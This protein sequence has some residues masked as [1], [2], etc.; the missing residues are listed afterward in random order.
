MSTLRAE[1]ADYLAMRRA[2]GFS[3]KRDEKLLAQF[4]DFLQ[5]QHTDLV[6][7][8]AALA[9]ASLPAGGPSWL[10]L[11]LSVVR[12]FA[13]HLHTLNPL[14][15]VPPPGLLPGRA[16]RMVP[17]L[18]CDADILAL[19]DAT[20]TLR[21]EL[22]RATYRTL[23]GLLAAT[24]MR[25]GEAL[26]LDTADLDLGQGLLTVRHGKSDT[27]RL[28]PLH[29]ST[30]S[31]LADYLERRGTLKP[32]PTI[33][34]SA[35]FVSTAGTRLAYVNVSVVFPKLLAR[36]AIATRSERC[37]P[38]LH[39]L[40]HSFA[41]AT[42]LSWYRDGGPIPPRLPWLSTYLGHTEP[43]NTYWYLHASPELL[44]QA[45]RRLEKYQ[46]DRL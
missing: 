18:Y 28:L 32:N 15:Q 24:G 3:L 2:L 39:D 45:A 37:R 8:E 11:R 44:E 16:Q 27:T 29:P 7:V 36:T 33:A 43:K 4:L 1:L 9:W 35:L 10:G 12:A 6:T 34:T 19:M 22:G 21:Y 25:I 42:L 41:V 30:L 13:R 38:R 14:H 26:A 5:E 40:R 23:V 17:F 20:A 46:E 31:A